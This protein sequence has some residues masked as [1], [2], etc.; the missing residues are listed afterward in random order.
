MLRWTQQNG[1]IGM[2]IIVRGYEGYVLATR[3]LT[4]LGNKELVAAE[5][6]AAL[7]AVESGSDLGQ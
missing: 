1:R 6:L 4:K 7:N 5:A 3:S 2:C